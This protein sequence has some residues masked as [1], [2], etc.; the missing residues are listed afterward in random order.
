MIAYM[1]YT[2][3]GGFT[4][5]NA[6]FYKNKVGQLDDTL[7]FRLI[8]YVIIKITRRGTTV[9]LYVFAAKQPKKE[10]KLGLKI[11]VSKLRASGNGLKKVQKQ[12]KD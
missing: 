10:H 9:H 2:P 5:N 1:H 8:V 3:N 12:G 4:D 6:S 7:Q 11:F